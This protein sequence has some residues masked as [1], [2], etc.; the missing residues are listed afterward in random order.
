VQ[1]ALLAAARQRSAEADVRYQSGLLTYDN[2]EIIVSDRISTE[3]QAISA[4]LAAVNAEA[5]WERS[6]GKGLGE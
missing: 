2:W 4:K 6:L 3:R 1:Q 5:A